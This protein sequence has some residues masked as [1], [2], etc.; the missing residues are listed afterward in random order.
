[1]NSKD[2]GLYP[3]TLSVVYAVCRVKAVMSIRGCMPTMFS[4]VTRT[5]LWKLRLS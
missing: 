1:M 3:S 5:P 2:A 4:I